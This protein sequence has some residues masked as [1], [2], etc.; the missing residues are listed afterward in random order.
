[1]PRLKEKVGK[2][3]QALSSAY[4]KTP[5]IAVVL[6]S[7]MS[8]VVSAFSNLQTVPFDQIP[9]YSESTV[10][11]HEGKWIFSEIEGIP[12]LFIQ[13]RLHYYEGHSLQQV[14]YPIHLIASMGIKTLLLTS[15][16]GGLNPTW[17]PGDLMLI[18]DHI[19]F[20]FHNP[21]IGDPKHQLGPRF[22]DLHQ[23]YDN[24]LIS[25][26]LRAGRLEGIDFK[27]GV[28]CWLSGPNYETAAEVNMLRMLGADAVSMSI[29]P[30]VIVAAQRH[31]NV[32]ALALI[33]NLAT[34]LADT[35]LTHT[36]VIERANFACKRLE[37]FLRRFVKLYNN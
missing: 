18:R 6:G 10:P 28:F 1:M 16:S 32:L 19:N 36:E 5:E 8:K 33:T 14:T 3:L 7:G 13:G 24:K 34:G 12:C 20:V 4:S 11:G 2:S 15:A 23:P 27:Q 37:L 35:V 30:E 25:L 31:L 17:N 22:P 9:Y 29:V 26:A 21:L